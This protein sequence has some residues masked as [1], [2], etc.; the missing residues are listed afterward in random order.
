MRGLLTALGALLIAAGSLFALQGAGIV[1]WPAE[2]FM[3]R[4]ASWVTYGIAIA[5][6]GV[7]LLALARRRRR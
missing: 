1:M 2:S 5:L 4:E 3:L 6:V 7:A